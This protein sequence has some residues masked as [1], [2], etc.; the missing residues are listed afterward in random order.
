MVYRVGFPLIVTYEVIGLSDKRLLV[1][2]RLRS[3]R[4]HVCLVK[5]AT[6]TIYIRIISDLR[7]DRLNSLNFRVTKSNRIWRHSIH[8]VRAGLTIPDGDTLRGCRFL[9]IQTTETIYRVIPQIAIYVHTR[10][11]R[12]I[13]QEAVDI[14]ARLTVVF[15]RVPH[16]SFR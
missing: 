16:R 13:I 7:G 1:C 9:C 4:I 3:T 11:I 6:E 10:S 5:T 2:N 14:P 8:Q 12:V 15:R